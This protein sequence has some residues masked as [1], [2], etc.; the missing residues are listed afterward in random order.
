L[1]GNVQAVSEHEKNVIWQVVQGVGCLVDFEQVQDQLVGGVG[2]CL[3]LDDC[4]AGGC[5]VLDIQRQV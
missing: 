4:V 2:D 5:E 3:R 1:V